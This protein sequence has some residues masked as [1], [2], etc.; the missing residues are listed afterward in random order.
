MTWMLLSSLAL[1]APAMLDAGTLAPFD[2]S[3]EEEPSRGPWWAT[4]DD[5]VLVETVD[6][7]TR[8]NEELG[9][10]WARVA[11]AD[12]NLWVVG[13]PLLPAASFDVSTTGQPLDNVAFCSVGQPD[14]LNPPDADWCWQGS[15][16]LNARWQLDVFGTNALATRA[17]AFEAQATKGD[18]DAQ[19][20]QV[21][22]RVAGAY[23]DVVA[24]ARQ[25]DIV[26]TQLQ[27]QRDLLTVVEL[28]FEQGSSTSLD[29]L[30]QRSAVSAAEA[31]LPPA[32][33]S[34]Q[35]TEQALAVLLG[36]DPRADIPTAEVLPELG[37]PPAPGTPEGL[38]ARRPDLRAATLRHRASK[39]QLT[40]ATLSL[41]PTLQANA[42]AGWNYVFAPDLDTLEGWSVGGTLSVPLFNGGATHGRIRGARANRD[43]AVHSWNQALLQATSEV[44]QALLQDRENA[45]RRTA[46]DQQLG[47]ARLAYEESR[48]RYLAGIDTFLTVLTAWNSLQQAE[49]NS[50]QAH[51]DQ[52][53]ARINL[54]VALG[55]SP[56]APGDTP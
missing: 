7:A 1:A 33:I 51:R 12:A 27:S 45:T 18:R 35:A 50:L 21:A 54:F 16:R 43:V 23:L 24:A 22:A 42:G 28:R 44:H 2:A 37:P 31:L 30:Q 36:A 17:A 49:L 20:L 9:A 34:V 13:S 55:G 3:E 25:L 53:T 8:S 19:E 39:A 38:A 41:A 48:E 4:L 52:L 14:F 10:A 15:A 40:S 11:A 5:P 29:V 46:V 47:A 26:Q 6:T 32:R 56:S